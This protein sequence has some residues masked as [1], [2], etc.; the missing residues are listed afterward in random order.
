MK[1]LVLL[2]AVFMGLISKAQSVVKTLQL[3]PDTGQVISYSAT[4]GED[5]DYSINTPSYLSNGDG[6]VTDLV[7]GLMWQQTDGGEM[8]IEAATTYCNSLTIGGY[9][10]WRLPT[11][12]ESFSILNQQNVNPAISTTYFTSTLADYWWTDTFQ[13]G[14]SSKVWVTNAGGGIGNHPKTETLSAGGVKKFHVRAVRDVTTP[15]V[16]TN[17][18]TV[19]GDGTVT[20][21][22]TQLIWQELPNSI[23][24][25]WEQ[26]LLY[27]EGLNLAGQTD[28]RLPNIKELQSLSD[29]SNVNPALNST[30]FSALGV[31]NY[32]SSTTLKPNSTNPAS[33]WYW[34]TQ[35]GITTYDLKSN[36][37]YVLCVRGNPTLLDNQSVINSS[38]KIKVISNP[39]TSKIVFNK[40]NNDFYSELFSISGQLL[41]SGNAIEKQDFTSLKK[42][43]YILK[44]SGVGEAIKLVKE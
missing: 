33:A 18:Y 13:F 24:Q 14:D 12:L 44:I 40:T 17:H 19:N 8:T 25:T 26:A 27:A 41:Y 30:F 11:P 10:D 22:V 20:D 35:F 43:V 39:F 5:N 37:N 7:T 16:L 2:L 34:N 1:R 23:S 31:H 3:L 4:Y 15:S 42:G 32:W 21:N 6:T 29:Y 9:T 38:K 28:W 36:L